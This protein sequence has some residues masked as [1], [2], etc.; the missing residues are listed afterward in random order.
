M[1]HKHTFK[2]AFHSWLV[3]RINFETYVA[4]AARRH[5]VFYR[6]NRMEAEFEQFNTI[7]MGDAMSSIEGLVSVNVSMHHC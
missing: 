7:Y 4:L 1:I 3:F 5:I 2:G 6:W